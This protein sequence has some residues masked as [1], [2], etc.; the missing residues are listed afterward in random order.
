MTKARMEAILV[1]VIAQ[2][3]ATRVRYI[4][5]EANDGPRIDDQM[6]Q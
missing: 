5:V 6:E 1:D 3:N 2:K 4:I